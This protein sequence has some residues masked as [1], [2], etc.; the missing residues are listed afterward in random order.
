MD[1]PIHGDLHLTPEEVSCA[2]DGAEDVCE[3]VEP[4]E[5]G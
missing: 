5:V 2:V 3:T 1:W 4:L